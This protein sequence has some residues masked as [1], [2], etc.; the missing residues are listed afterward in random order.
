VSIQ[1]RWFDDEKRILLYEFVGVWTWED[2]YAVL[3]QATEMS[4]SVNHPVDAIV[5]LTRN[6]STPMG[7]LL[8]L[9]QIT[10][11][12]TVTWNTA[13]LI[14]A[15]VITRGVVAT[16]RGLYPRSGAR[17]HTANSFPEAVEIIEK[18]RQQLAKLE[19]M[20]QK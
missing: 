12:E 5:D 8:N 15:N 9:R 20:D 10:S 4:L 17:V 2:L 16:F 6:G 19:P 14:G 3:K 7:A 18:R 11:W 13:V 1:I